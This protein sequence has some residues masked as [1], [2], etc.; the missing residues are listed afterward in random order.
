MP[1][2]SAQSLE[3]AA[4]TVADEEGMQQETAEA[5]RVRDSGGV[6]ALLSHVEAAFAWCNWALDPLVLPAAAAASME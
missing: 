3:S 1:D 6:P 5:Q 4:N 2:P